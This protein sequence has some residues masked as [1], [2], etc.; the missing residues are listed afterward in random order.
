MWVTKEKAAE[1]LE[2][3]VATINR[4]VREGVTLH[5]GRFVDLDEVQAEYRRRR[6]RLEE[7]Q[8]T[9]RPRNSGHVP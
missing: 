6:A 8:M 1:H 4:Y 3:K 2:V 5:L 9:R 7:A